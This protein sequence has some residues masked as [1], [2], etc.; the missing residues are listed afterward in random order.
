M[1]RRALPALAWPA[2]AGAQPRIV[3]IILG[4]TPGGPTDGFARIVA[5]ELAARWNATVV[6][7]NRPGASTMLAAEAVA[8]ARPDGNTLLMAAGSHTSLPALR[9]LP[10]DT[11]R[12]FSGLGIIAETPHALTL[13]AAAPDRTVAAFAARARAAAQPLTYSSSSAGGTVHLAGALFARQIGA[14][15]LHVPYRGA[16]QAITDLA[17]GVVDCALATL[18]SVLPLLRG[19]E[20]RALA[21]TGDRRFPALP[22]VPTFAESG[23]PEYRISTWYAL[24]APA[25]LPA[26]ELDRLSGD[27]RAVIARPA[28]LAA[29]AAQAAWPGDT[30]RHDFD[31][32]IAR[33]VAQWGEL[34][35]AAGIRAE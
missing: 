13:Q 32:L 27:L 24:L 3:R 35:R 8:R 14:E 1:K 16:A 23:M 17:S 25:G 21:L 4:Y 9:P 31:A 26:T 33:E 15:M 28:M 22:G 20:L 5:P 10:Y 29:I 12:D 18:P 2:L 11:L 6:V 34:A 7:E 30:F 19:A